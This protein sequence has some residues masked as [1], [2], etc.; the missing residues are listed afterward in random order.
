MS[1]SNSQT[2]RMM[3]LGSAFGLGAFITMFVF[4]I[5]IPVA[6]GFAI[7]GYIV[8]GIFLMMRTGEARI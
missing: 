3:L 6:F 4:D 5:S 7:F 8:S 1:K 2:K